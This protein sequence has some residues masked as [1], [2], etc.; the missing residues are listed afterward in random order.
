MAARMPKND[1]VNTTRT[2]SKTVV[3]ADNDCANGM[4]G[5][6]LHTD[7]HLTNHSDL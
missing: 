7:L 4:V 6:E 2:E 1:R 3:I 5:A